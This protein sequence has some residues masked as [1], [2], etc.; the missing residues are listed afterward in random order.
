MFER[1]R[2]CNNKRRGKNR[3]GDTPMDGEKNTEH[4]KKAEKTLDK[5]TH[6]RYCRFSS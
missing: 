4:K 3:R 6:P 5:N 1:G 2:I